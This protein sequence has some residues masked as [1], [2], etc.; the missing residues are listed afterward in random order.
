MIDYMKYLKCFKGIT[1]RI[2]I[3]YKCNMFSYCKYCYSKEELKEFKDDMTVKN[4]NDVISW[5]KD[6][7]DIDDVVFLGGE[8]TFH[9]ELEKIGNILNKKK[10]GCFIFTN[11][12][13]NKEKLDILKK[14][15]AFHTIIFH[16]EEK[17]LSNKKLR[18][19]FLR[20]LEEL[21]KLKNI[22][23]RFNTGDPN[24]NFKDLIDLSKKYN[25]SIAYSFTS[26][27]LNREIN[28]VKISDMKKF[29]P[30]LKE[31][32]KVAYENNIELLNKRPLPLCIF[33]EKD[34]NM[35]KEM[36]GVRSVCC[37]G[38]VCVNPDL[39]LY[40]AP[41]LMPIK[42]NPVKN[43]EDLIKKV[44]LLKGEIEKLKWQVPTIPK[45]ISCKH[46]KKHEC[47]GGCTVYKLIS[48]SD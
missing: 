24:F 5:F 22:M 17:F 1:P 12:C 42:T 13:F 29:I 25:A 18:K 4:F 27:T 3:T 36:G 11:G 2:N 10:V 26:P 30:C 35:V 34:V 33:D 7:Y 20:N 9:T 6:A 32:I 47:Q 38:S 46:W 16:Y 28:Y 31:F 45:C 39:S 40:A 14:I 21:S 41:T 8:I 48:R 44:N 19:I 37:V 43:K 15:N 23:F